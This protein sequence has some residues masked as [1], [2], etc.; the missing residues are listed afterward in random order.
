M[1]LLT[2]I[3]WAVFV[4]VVTSVCVTVIR[5]LSRRLGEARKEGGA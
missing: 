5:Y 4:V 1:D 2:T 3:G